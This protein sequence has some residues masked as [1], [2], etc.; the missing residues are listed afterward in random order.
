MPS[1]TMIRIR[2]TA[3]RVSAVALSSLLMWRLRAERMCQQKNAS[4]IE[5]ET[6]AMRN[7]GPHA[8][9]AVRATA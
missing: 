4:R 1:T 5:Y 9:A 6:N 7:F 8:S 2:H 3:M